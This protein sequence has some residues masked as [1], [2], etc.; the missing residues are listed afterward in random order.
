M[1]HFLIHAVV[2]EEI[3]SKLCIE[4]TTLRTFRRGIG[5]GQHIPKHLV[6]LLIHAKDECVIEIALQVL[7]NLTL[8]TECLYSIE[9]M[10]RTEAGRNALSDLQNLLTVSKQAFTEFRALRAVIDHL[11]SNLEKDPKLSLEQCESIN[12]CLMLLRNILHIPSADYDDLQKRNFLVMQNQ[13]IWNLFA[14]CIDKLLIH[15]ISCPQK[16][17]FGV[18]VVQVVALLYKDQH[19]STLQKLLCAWFEA[20]VSDS[21]EDFESYTTPLKQTNGNDSSAICTSDSSDNGG[22]IKK[23]VIFMNKIR[24]IFL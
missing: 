5:F 21:S 23:K 12:N 3:F 17:L 6:P 13:I 7:V 4:D 2:L 24:I 16:A 14:L 9:I 22:G 11:R 20:S 19:I 10:Q 18:N 8:P 15:L 1:Y